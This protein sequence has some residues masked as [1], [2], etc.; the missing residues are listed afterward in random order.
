MTFGDKIMIAIFRSAFAVVI[1]AALAS[2]P[3]G[4]AAA[5]EE[6]RVRAFSTWQ[7]QGQMLQTGPSEAT[8]IG[9]LSG[10][11]YIDTDQGPVDAGTM[12]CPVV[13]TVD[14]KTRTQKGVGRCTIT[15]PQ[16]NRVY[17]EL[18]CTGV[19]LVGCAGDSKLTGGTGPFAHVT[20]GGHFVLRSGLHELAAKGDAT[21]K[22]TAT[23]I[24]FWREFN[25]QI[26]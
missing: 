5:A 18:T 13:V 24:T 4:A 7:G 12:V 14:L 17:M 10:R 23:G 15:G 2:G 26:P 1:V 19:P 25:Y 3:T 6:Q 9:M 20:G 21:V 8:F 16:G 11:L 22:D